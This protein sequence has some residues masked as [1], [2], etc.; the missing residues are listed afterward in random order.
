MALSPEGRARPEE[1]KKLPLSSFLDRRIGPIIGQL[2]LVG[3]TKVPIWGVYKLLYERTTF[4]QVLDPLTILESKEPPHILTE[5]VFDF[6][7]PSVESKGIVGLEGDRTISGQSRAFLFT[8]SILNDIKWTDPLSYLDFARARVFLNYFGVEKEMENDFTNIGVEIAEFPKIPTAIGE[9]ER[10]LAFLLLEQLRQRGSILAGESS[11]IMLMMEYIFAVDGLHG[12]LNLCDIVRRFFGKDFTLVM[13]DKEDSKMSRS[14]ASDA[15]FYRYRLS[16]TDTRLPPLM[17]GMAGIGDIERAY[18]AYIPYPPGIVIPERTPTMGL[19][20]PPRRTNP[21]F[22]GYRYGHALNTINRAFEDGLLNPRRISFLIDRWANAPSP[23]FHQYQDLGLTIVEE[24]EGLL[25][26]VLSPLS[27]SNDLDHIIAS[28]PPDLSKWTEYVNDKVPLEARILPVTNFIRRN[29]DLSDASIGK[30]GTITGFPPSMFQY[31]K[32][33]REGASV[34]ALD[35][36][37]D[38]SNTYLLSIVNN[39]LF[40]LSGMHISVNKNNPLDLV[41]ADGL[42]PTMFVYRTISSADML[43]LIRVVGA[44]NVLSVLREFKVQPL[45]EPERRMEEQLLLFNNYK[46]QLDRELTG[47]PPPPIK[48]YTRGVPLMHGLW[49]WNDVSGITKYGTGIINIMILIP[50]HRVLE[51]YYKNLKL[52][53]TTPESLLL[54]MSISE[55]PE[56]VKHTEFIKDFTELWGLSADDYA[57]MLASL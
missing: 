37:S 51:K 29:P 47:P 44:P 49:G 22:I 9:D 8:W 40:G 42:I 57:K 4:F 11:Y 26:S 20:M 32:L 56:T 25:G 28:L 36:I 33:K 16:E 2:F 46:P 6:E 55:K 1:K 27:Y 13:I 3:K 17:H 23:T 21:T 7:T 53:S 31:I 39:L 54:A 43:S 48:I 35:I 30:L 15:L 45:D 18:P 41:R 12:L 50:S 19:G 52:C 38:L 24:K 34:A 14:L 5:G 10:E